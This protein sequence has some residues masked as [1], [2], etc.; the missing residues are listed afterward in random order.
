M[1]IIS[2]FR[3]N[4]YVNHS[5]LH[6][7][8]HCQ[9]ARIYVHKCQFGFETIL[10]LRKKALNNRLLIL[11]ITKMCNRTKLSSFSLIYLFIFLDNR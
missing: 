4:I 7:V 2:F 8:C 5:I 9:N 6:A 1:F 11:N 10:K 3:S